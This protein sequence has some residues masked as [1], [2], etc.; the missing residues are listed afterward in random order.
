MCLDFSLIRLHKYLL[1]RNLFNGYIAFIWDE[2]IR[3]M[4]A[5]DDDVTFCGWDIDVRST[6]NCMFN[7]LSEHFWVSIWDLIDRTIWMSP[8]WVGEKWIYEDIAFFYRDDICSTWYCTFLDMNIM[9]DRY[10]NIIP[11]KVSLDINWISADLAF[12]CFEFLGRKIIWRNCPYITIDLGRYGW[13]I[14]MNDGTI[15]FDI[16]WVIF[17]YTSKYFELFVLNRVF[18]IRFIRK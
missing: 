3:S 9:I 2:L 18:W 11:L 7:W 4:W 8:V 14:C 15:Y 10:L 5:R 16:V 13:G 12:L 1:I 17:R 6:L